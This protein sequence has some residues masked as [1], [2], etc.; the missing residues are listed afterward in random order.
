[1]ITRLISLGNVI[2]DIVAEVEALP[3]RGSDVLASRA[4]P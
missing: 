2:I 3:E 4:A 1:M